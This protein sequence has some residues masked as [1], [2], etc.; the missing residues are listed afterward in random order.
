MHRT[1]LRRAGTAAFVALL[2]APVACSSH[3]ASHPKAAASPQPPP[4]GGDF[5]IDWDRPLQGGKVLASA[6]DASSSIAFTPVV[7]KFSTS[8]H[9]IEVDQGGL[10]VDQRAIAFAYDM[11]TLGKVVM[12]ERKAPY[13]Q[14]TLLGMAS[15]NSFGPGAYQVVSARGSKALLIQGRG[16]GRLQWIEQGLLFD[17]YGESISPAAVQQ[18]AAQV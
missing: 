10:T 2:L 12:V 1:H 11:P 6:A 13:S 15:N 17:L 5:D 14:D 8:P 18:L 7:P 16:I 9:V 4:G 3:P